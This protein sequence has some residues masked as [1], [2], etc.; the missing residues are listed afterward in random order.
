[1][2]GFGQPKCLLRPRFL[3]QPNFQDICNWGMAQVSWN[4]GYR[5]SLPEIFPARHIF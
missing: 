3:Q 1:M 4:L 5:A 2:T